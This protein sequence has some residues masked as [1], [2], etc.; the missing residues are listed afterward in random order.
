MSH[1]IDQ[2]LDLTPPAPLFKCALHSLWRRDIR[3]PRLLTSAFFPKRPHPPGSSRRAGGL[4][5]VLR[6]TT[7][8]GGLLASS[9]G[10]DAGPYRMDLRQT[11]VFCT[12]IAVRQ[13]F[14]LP[15]NVLLVACCYQ[16]GQGRLELTKTASCSRPRSWTGTRKPRSP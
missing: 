6:F 2:W 1:T 14:S 7:A 11:D 13:P 15:P 4:S 12:Q 10:L 8:K 5:S 3:A 9:H 16:E